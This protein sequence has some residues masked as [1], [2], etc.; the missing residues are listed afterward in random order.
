MDQIQQIPLEQLYP[1]EGNRR[2]GG[3]DKAKLEQLA[4][5]IKAVGVQQPAV[6]RKIVFPPGPTSELARRGVT[7]EIVAGERRW[8]AAKLAGL[9]AL[10]CVVRE[11]D[12][13][14]V[15]KIQTIENLQREDIHP[16]DEASGYARLIERAG[17]DVEHLAGEVGRSVSYVY[18]RLKLLELVPKAREALIK[19]KITAGHAILVARLQPQGQQEALKEITAAWRDSRV[20]GPMTIG[21]L[22]D[23]I[24]ENILLDLSKAAFKRNDAD[25]VPAA[26]PC[27]SCPK[28]TG[29]QPALFADVCNDGKRDY[30]LDRAC[31]KAKQDALLARHR[32]EI[33]TGEH[34]EVIGRNGVS[35]QEE[36]KLIKAGVKR[37]HEWQECKAGDKDA[38]RVLIVAGAERGRLT[39]GVE[40]KQPSYTYQR[41]PQQKAAEERRRREEKIASMTRQRLWD[42]VMARAK[43]RLAREIPEDLLRGI[44]LAYFERLWDDARDAL[45]KAE[46]WERPEKKPG[47]YGKPWR[48]MGPKKLVG[49]T[50]PELRVFLFKCSLAPE[51]L[52]HHNYISNMKDDLQGAAKQLGV[53]A[54]AIAAE[55]KKEAAAA[56]AAK[57]ARQMKKTKTSAPAKKAPAGKKKRAPRETAPAGGVRK[58]RFCGCTDDDCH[59]CIEKTGK[60]CHWVEDDLCSACVDQP[61]AGARKRAK[62]EKVHA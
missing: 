27:T 60:P 16:L 1:H 59:Q 4:E 45:V 30:C 18:Q 23:W 32:A 31:F 43:E 57:K 42:A 54:A 10:P 44:A 47:V 7:H 40:R 35:W 36:Q 46:A 15:L 51:L 37:S 8:R 14:T 52:G 38:Q 9:D 62:K 61:R 29:F 13:V 3:F 41:S 21:E 11:L 25:L 26:G 39:W 20:D 22:E 17:Y 5:S 48:D 53:D 28:R 33:K 58:C 50:A 55:V 49:M 12:D 19:G 24:Q 6:V 34:L 2:V 56:A